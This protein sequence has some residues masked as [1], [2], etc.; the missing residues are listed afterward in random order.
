MKLLLITALLA[1]AACAAHAET[2]TFTG[3]SKIIDGVVLLPATP[4]GRPAGAQVFT[5]AT[6]ATFAD[7]KTVT[8]NG[9][10]AAWVL[11]PGS[12]FGNSGV[13]HY[14]ED[15]APVYALQYSCEIPEK[16][17]AGVNCWGEL[18]GEG[19]PWKGRTGTVAFFSLTG[20]STRGT[21]QWN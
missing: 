6:L 8:T 9:K 15:K 20:G 14:T 5:G 17:G 10:C 12:P 16:G 13:C 2:F 18:I 19:G 4:S 11:P 7:G 21:G 1:S 3:T